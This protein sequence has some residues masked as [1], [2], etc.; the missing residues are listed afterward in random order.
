MPRAIWSGAVSFGLVS[1]PVKLYTAVSKKNVSFNQLDRRTGSRIKQK[2]VSAIDG[3]EVPRSEIVKGYEVSRD[4]YV[5][6]D[7]DELAS[8]MPKESR[9]IDISDFIEQA[10]IDP[11]LYQTAYYLVP[12][13]LARKSYALLVNAMAE[14][15]RVGIATFV[16]RGKQHLA[17]LRPVDGMLMLSTMNYADELADPAELPGFDELADIEFSEPEMAM[18]NQLI[19]SLSGEFEPEKYEDTYRLAVM[20]LLER[21]AAGDLTVAELPAAAD[22][23]SVVD[24]LAAL[25]ASVAAAKDSRKRHP[26]K[27]T[28]AK[29]ASKKAAAKKTGRKKAKDDEVAEPVAKSA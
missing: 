20:D 13:E 2:K 22:D 6:V 25:E 4:S 14:A 26:S 12:D 10:D 16:M 27:K 29:K 28:P 3:E 23:D 24:L 5:I 21:K 11:V 19:E 18:A 9:T 7:E 1:I 17:A 15:D 8:L